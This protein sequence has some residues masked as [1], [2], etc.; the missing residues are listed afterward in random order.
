[1]AAVCLVCGKKKAIAKA[2]GQCAD[3]ALNRKIKICSSCNKRFKITKE[4]QRKCEKCKNKVAK[5]P[6]KR[7]AKRR[8]VWIVASAGLPGLGKKK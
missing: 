1:M 7:G 3:C 6:A 2:G 5:K 8:S 4:R